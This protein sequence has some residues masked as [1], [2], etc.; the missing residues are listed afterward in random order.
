MYDSSG[1]IH[2]CG[3]F[4]RIRLRRRA[5]PLGLRSRGSWRPSIG[6]GAGAAS[7]ASRCLNPGQWG[8]DVMRCAQ[9]KI[10]HEGDGP[11][12]G[13][14]AGHGMVAPFCPPH[15]NRA[16]QR[17]QGR[18]RALP[19]PRRPPAISKVFTARTKTTQSG[20]GAGA[21]A[22]GAM[23]SISPRHSST[24]LIMW[25]PCGSSQRNIICNGRSV[26]RMG[27][28]LISSI[29]R[30]SSTRAGLPAFR[31]YCH[32]PRLRELAASLLPSQH[33]SQ[34]AVI[35]ALT[36]PWSVAGVERL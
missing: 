23:C 12:A 29:A 30:R 25:P 14:P 31:F 17:A 33:C 9:P 34:E 24:T 22:A 1:R 18:D 26:R 16:S 2:L 21:A 3:T 20:S 11:R 19:V 35:E 15:R 7:A 4:G 36:S 5:C 32:R 13:T 28:P 6:Q 10:R 27:G 8:N